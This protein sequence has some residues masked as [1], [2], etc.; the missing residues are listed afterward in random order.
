MQTLD[1]V[2]LTLEDTNQ[3]FLMRALQRV[4]NTLETQWKNVLEAQIKKI[5]DTKVKIKKRKGVID[6]I[7][8]FPSFVAAVETMLAPPSDVSSYGPSERTET[9]QMM[10]GAY[11]RLN[12]QMFDSLKTIAKESP[13]IS[14]QGQQSMGALAAADPEDKEALNY[15]ILLIE[16]M[17]HYLEEVDD[18]GD[19]VLMDWRG[20]AAE[21]Y[22]EHLNLYVNSVVRRPM[23]KLLVSAHASNR[24]EISKLIN[25]RT[26]SIPRPPRCL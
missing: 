6:F 1:R 17:H 5:D 8:V 14:A 21:E 9:R 20:K 18:H 26:T 3:E 23:G 19:G 16:N 7:R 15:H 11:E 25:R 22:E 12:K 2:M 24:A 10:D 4:R 13:G